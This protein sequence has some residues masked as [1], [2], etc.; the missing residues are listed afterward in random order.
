L[1]SNNNIENYYKTVS[2]PPGSSEL[3][4]EAYKKLGIIVDY[5]NDNPSV[6]IW[7]IGYSGKSDN[8]DD[9][10][11]QKIAQKRS[12][13]IY[14]FLTGN[15]INKNRI[16]L[17]YATSGCIERSEDNNTTLPCNSA[18]ILMSDDREDIKKINSPFYNQMP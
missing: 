11:Q 13:E 15:R 2:F 12:R 7:I 8:E 14:I 5:M 10:E 9:S 18:E 16:S 4:Y 1:N 3:T 17:N 6:T